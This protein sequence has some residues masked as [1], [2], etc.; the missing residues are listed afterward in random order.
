MS[1][2]KRWPSRLDVVDEEGELLRFE[3]QNTVRAGVGEAGA[4]MPPFE[5]HVLRNPSPDRVCLTL[6]VYAGEM[7][8][9]TTFEPVRGD[10]FRRVT[11]PLSYDD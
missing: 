6:H 10:W 9:C 5:Y 8:E 2:S 4:L 11:L 1:L 7:T 3:R